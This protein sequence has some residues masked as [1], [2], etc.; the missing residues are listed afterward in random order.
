MRSPDSLLIPADPAATLELNEDDLADI[1]AAVH[2]T[3]M[4]GAIVGAG[5]PGRSTAGYPPGSGR[6]HTPRR[7]RAEIVLPAACHR[8]PGA[9]RKKTRALNVAGCPRT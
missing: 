2:T 4:T 8:N 6:P 3:V 9:G 7:V 1:A 5:G